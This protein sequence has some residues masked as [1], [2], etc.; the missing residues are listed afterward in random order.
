[1]VQ[2]EMA[3][4]KDGERALTGENECCCRR[5]RSYARREAGA[6]ERLEPPASPATTSSGACATLAPVKTAKRIRLITEAANSLREK[7]WAIIQ[8]TLDQFGFQTHEPSWE[9]DVH[10]YCVQ[11][12]KNGHDDQIGELHQYLVG[13]DPTPE[14]LTADQPWGELP[15]RLFLS[16]IHP[17]GQLAGRVKL[18]LADFGV[19]AFVAHDDIEPG[20]EWR[21]VIKTALATCHALTAFLHS[22]FH[23]SQWCDQEIGWALGRHLLIIPVRFDEE[24]K[25]RDGFINDYQDVIAARF[26]GLPLARPAWLAER[27]FTRMLNDART[28]EVGVRALAEAFVRCRSYDQT[29]KLYA[30]LAR[31]EAIAPE[32]LRRLE[33][34]VQE[35]PQVYEAVL[36]SRPIPDLIG[37]FIKRH[38][39]PAPV[40]PWGDA[41]F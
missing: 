9:F 22:G 1:M 4:L 11:Q 5:W 14:T 40:D 37:E 6:S 41:P 35:N 17:H 39:P 12:I 15:A 28:K 19:D 29:R 18:A 8:L 13:R 26:T 31:Q 16:H 32:Q 36:G 20:D 33:C 10:D 34:A 3:L 7:D 38:D 30:L 21:A 24:D 27:I 2:K 25:R 23:D